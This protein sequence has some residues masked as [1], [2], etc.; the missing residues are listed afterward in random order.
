[1]SK[2]TGIV[3]GLALALVLGLSLAAQAGEWSRKSLKDVAPGEEIT[4]EEATLK[5]KIVGREEKDEDGE[6]ITSAFL[7]GEDGELIPLPCEPKRD[8]EKGLAG[9]AAGK[10]KG[11]QSCWKYLG[12][13]VEILGS[14]QSVMKKGKRVRQLGKITG[15]NPL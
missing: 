15:I 5:G 6:K 13:E 9:K 8:K 11:D 10:L 4:T 7:E 1:M 14:A 12:Q 3:A 2:Q